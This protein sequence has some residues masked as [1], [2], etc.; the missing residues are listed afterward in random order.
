MTFDLSQEIT[1]GIK[2][3]MNEEL[4]ESGLRAAFQVV[5]LNGGLGFTLPNHR[6]PVYPF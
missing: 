5:R 3:Q 4:P 2:R 1:E 6:Q